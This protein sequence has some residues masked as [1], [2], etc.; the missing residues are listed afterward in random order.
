MIGGCLPVA[1]GSILLL[2]NCKLANW[3]VFSKFLPS[4]LA[5]LLL[6]CSIS[7][8]SLGI[9]NVLSMY[10]KRSAFRESETRCVLNI[11]GTL[12]APITSFIFLSIEVLAVGN[13]SWCLLNYS[14]RF[15][16]A[17]SCFAHWSKL[18]L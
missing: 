2:S 9:L 13:A 6:I 18:A 3:L 4:M 14:W 1:S 8:S 11:S 16:S 7:S 5:T 15:F 10:C 17:L 12:L